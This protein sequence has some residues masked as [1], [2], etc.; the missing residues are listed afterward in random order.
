MYNQVDIFYFWVENSY[1]VIHDA[2]IL[3]IVSG[4]YYIPLDLLSR[5]LEKLLI[6]SGVVYP[7]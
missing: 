6:M 7:I 4:G 5:G 1:L 2:L 3:L